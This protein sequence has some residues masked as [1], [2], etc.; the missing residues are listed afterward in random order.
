M[1]TKKAFSVKPKY[2]EIN[3]NILYSIL[4]IK[5]IKKHENII[6]LNFCS[7]KNCFC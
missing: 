3:L 2:I 6:Y 1:L 4:R 7:C 5:H